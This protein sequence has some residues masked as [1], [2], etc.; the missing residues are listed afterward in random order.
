MGY[1]IIGILIFA[2]NVATGFIYK[3]A[4]LPLD[5]ISLSLIGYGLASVAVDL[6]YNESIWKGLMQVIN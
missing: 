3:W 4:S 1:L 6:I 2:L 5:V